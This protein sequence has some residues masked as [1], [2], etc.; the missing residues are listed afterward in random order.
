MKLL[1]ILP[2]IPVPANTGGTQ[3]TLNLVKSLDQAFDLT[4]LAPRLPSQ[5]LAS[6]EREIRGRVVTVPASARRSLVD[7]AMSAISGQPFGYRK[8]ASRKLRAALQALLSK[9]KFAAVHF[10]HIHTAQLLPIV[11]RRSPSARVCIDQHN[12]EAMVLERL[13]PVSRRWMQPLLAVQARRVRHLEE[14]LMRESDLVTACSSVDAGHL[15]AMGARTV[16]IIPNGVH[17]D[18]AAVPAPAPSEERRSVVFVGSLDWWPNVEAAERLVREIWPV[19][20]ARIRGARLVIV[21][22]N[23]PRPLQAAACEDIVVTGTVPSVAPYLATA[24]ATAIPLR[25]G[26]GTRL[27]VLEA[28]A[29]HVPVVA[30]RLAIEG[31]PFEHER[32]VLI[33]ESPHEYAD[34]LA[35]L[36]A[37]GA[38]RDRLVRAAAKVAAGFDWRAVGDALVQQYAELL[39]GRTDAPAQV[40]PIAP[41]LSAPFGRAGA[42]HE[43]RS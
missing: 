10:D 26:S 21:G 33:A 32:E 41:A 19:V 38:L 5:D 17:I 30:T 20:R 34:A 42:L 23:P 43:G 2:S 14:K 15:Q 40:V 31:L 3:R 27:K 11:R 18:F 4:V 29:A 16:R 35:R 6:F 12:V 25:A 1:A 39:G 37:D 9:E 24:F 22:R 13:V 7:E 28:C 36:E 8:F